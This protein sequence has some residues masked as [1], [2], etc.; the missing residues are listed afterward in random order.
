VPSEEPAVSS[1]FNGAAINVGEIYAQLARDVH[2]GTYS[3]P[4][5]EHPLH[6]ARLV[7]AVRRAGQRGERQNV[8]AL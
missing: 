2:A 1:G 3:T 7:H 6:N 8:G 4:G 5:F